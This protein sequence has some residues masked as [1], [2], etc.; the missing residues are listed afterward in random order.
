M[1]PPNEVSRASLSSAQADHIEDAQ[2]RDP[3]GQTGESEGQPHDGGHERCRH[4]ADGPAHPQTLRHDPVGPPFDVHAHEVQQPPS[5]V[6]LAGDD[7]QAD[8][9]DEPARAGQRNEN[10]SDEHDECAEAT[11]DAA[12]QP[13]RV[14]IGQHCAAPP[15]EAQTQLAPRSGTLPVVA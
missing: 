1:R 12:I 13:C 11:D 2:V 10:E 15:E 5:P 8:D 4:R 3:I 7:E 9:D 14:R 6:E